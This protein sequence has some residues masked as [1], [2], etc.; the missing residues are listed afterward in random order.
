[1]AKIVDPDALAQTTD[2]VFDT[3][4]LQIEIKSTGAIDADDGVT[5]QCIYSFAIEEW[6]ADESLRA[7]PFPFEP[8]GTGEQFD[9]ID[10]W[11]WK[12][13]ATRQ[14]LR[15]GGFS[16]RA[17]SG[18]NPTEQWM[19][20]TTLGD[21][22]VPASHTAYFQQASGGATTAADR[23]GPVNQVV[24]IWSDPNADG[25][26][27]DGF[28][29]TDYFKIFLREQG[30]VFDSY[31]LLTQQS[32]SA[33]TYRVYKLP[34]SNRPDLK[35][36]TADTSIATG[37]SGAPDTAPYSDMDI[38]YLVGTTFEAPATARAWSLNEVG[39]DGAGRWFICTSAGTLDAAGAANY[40]ANGGTGTFAAFTGE[41]QIGANYYSFNIIIDA[42]VDDLGGN[43]T[44]E[45]IYE[46]AKYMVR[47]NIDID[48]GAG[49]VTGKT[50]AELL[51]FVGDTLKTKAGVYIDDFNAADTNAITFLDVG[52]VERNFPFTA[53]L[54][55]QFSA[56][57]QADAAAWYHVFFTN[58]DAGDNA[59]A[60]FGTASAITVD[61]DGGSDM[62]GLVSAAASV[63]HGFAY[64]T[65]TQRGAASAGEDA[66]ITVVAGGQGT[67]GYIA[68][69]GTIQ[70]STANVISLVAP[71][72][73]AYDNPA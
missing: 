34:L 20:I 68:A 47:Q 63:A 54:T 19:N 9:L 1:M 55:I 28:D 26:A 59:G 45:Q 51:E 69:T 66:P 6:K 62:K 41:R 23:A 2:V 60:D 42:N 27:A 30:H 70:R 22:E 13:A 33:L 29:R 8:I 64:D 37:G 50:A 39:Q 44:K 7:Y 73:R 57:L 56:T 25:N 15:D 3:A 10:G 4:A 5:L 46:F 36:T 71:Q 48:A 38:T 43:P 35:N 24:Q 67:A 21:F 16:V 17:S 65:N 53:S 72:D 14:L 32:L 58:D 40:T 31:D 49:T 11:N 18:A 12:N 52:S 61:D